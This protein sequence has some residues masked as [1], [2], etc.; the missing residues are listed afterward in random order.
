MRVMGP[1]ARVLPRPVWITIKIMKVVA[2]A[3][4]ATAKR[5]ERERG[6]AS[7]SEREANNVL[8]MALR[9]KEGGVGWDGDGVG[10]K[11]EGVGVLGC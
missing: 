5:V 9:R 7:M 11:G 2:C 3:G 6:S 8:E 10:V 1:T 4:S